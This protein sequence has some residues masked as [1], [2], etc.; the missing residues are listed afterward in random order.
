MK[1]VIN[2]IERHANITFMSKINENK[3]Y[4]YINYYIDDNHFFVLLLVLIQ[5]YY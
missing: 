3:N 5:I 1:N 4:M 2:I